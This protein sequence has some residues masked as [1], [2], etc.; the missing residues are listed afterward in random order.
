M[1]AGIAREALIMVLRMRL[2]AGSLDD[3]DRVSHAVRR[4]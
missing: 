4:G 2:T 1:S 3:G